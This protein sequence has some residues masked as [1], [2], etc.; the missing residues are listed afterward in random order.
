[1]Q[2]TKNINHQNKSHKTTTITQED[3]SLF[4]GEL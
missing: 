3:H 4:H 1:V 2:H